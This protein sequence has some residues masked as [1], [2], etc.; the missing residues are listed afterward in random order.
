[1]HVSNCNAC[2]YIYIWYISKRLFKAYFFHQISTVQLLLDFTSEKGC[3][4]GQFEVWVNEL[5]VSKSDVASMGFVAL[6]AFFANAN[7]SSP[8]QKN[9]PKSSSRQLRCW[10]QIFKIL[11]LRKSFYPVPGGNGSKPPFWRVT[12]VAQKKF[13][14]SP[15]KMPWP[16]LSVGGVCDCFWGTLW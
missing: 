15:K 11:K 9:P 13:I 3:R 2:I 8:P 4:E 12:S 16:F 10:W 7:N 6:P 5:A 14:D 1:M